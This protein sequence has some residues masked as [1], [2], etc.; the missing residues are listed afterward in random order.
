MKEIF[1]V[2]FK[3]IKLYFGSFPSFLKY[4][5]FPV[6]GQLLG[7]F[8]ILGI[9]YLYINYLPLLMKHSIFTNYAIIFFT[10]ILI[11]LPGL[12]VMLKAFWDYIVAYGA[13]NSMIDGLIKSG[14]VYDF[15]AHNEV[16]IRKTPKF[17]SIWLI[18]SFIGTICMFPL[19]LIVGAILFVYFILVFQVF[20]F[21]PDENAFNCFKRSF[22]I[23][24]GKFGKT[25]ILMLLIGGFTMFLLPGLANYS[26]E[27]AKLTK[28]LAIPF[29]NLTNL[30]PVEEINKILPYR[31]NSLMLA[32]MFV[33]S[34][35]NFII[36]GF[37]LPI[38]TICWGL[39]YKQN[40]KAKAKIDKR[41]LKRAEGKE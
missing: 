20:V 7:L 26:L 32:Q 31:V 25:F 23:I 1:E 12:F 29:D 36:I 10:L 39:W 33:Q 27:Y 15:P 16:V 18:I 11:T 4:M 22:Q 28:Y 41:I 37:T 30:L 3:S 6:F 35:I 24:K 34:V 13:I 5:S 8:W 2:F 38:R 14:Y 9:T 19:L 21:E 17:I 40:A